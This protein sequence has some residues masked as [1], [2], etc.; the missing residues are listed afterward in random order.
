MSFAGG[1]ARREAW[2]LRKPFETSS[3]DSP[4]RRNFLKDFGLGAAAL[5]VGEGGPAGQSAQTGRMPGRPAPGNSE[6]QPAQPDNIMAI[7]AHP[8]DVFFA[9]GAPV[10][11]QAHL[12]ARGVFLSLSLGEKGSAAIAPP[13]YGEMQR[14]ASERA[15]AV[16]GAQVALL[17]YPDGE[18]PV[19]D[20]VKF[21]VCDLIREHKPGVIVTHWRGSWHKDHQA[22]HAIVNDAVFYAGLPAVARKEPAHAVHS[23]F[24]ADNWE[25]AAGFAAD[26]YLDVSDVFDRW[27]EACAVFPMWRGENGFR[28]NDYY[29]SLAVERGCLSDCRHAIAL[30]SP[31]EQLTRCLRGL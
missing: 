19:N 23:V 1:E 21:K 15:A 11:L 8:G 17:E 7:A 30:M 9:M 24:Y 26:T 6:M 16:L 3:M 5:S 25:D 14:E 4:T 27:I 29:T 20:D 2:R 13:R 18:V 22:C 12:G 28:Y 31:P 10:A